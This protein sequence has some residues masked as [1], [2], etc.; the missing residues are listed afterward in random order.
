MLLARDGFSV[1][2]HGREQK[3]LE[4][5]KASILS[6]FPSSILETFCYDLSLMSNTKEFADDV[7]SK[8]TELSIL[9]NNAGVFQQSQII[10]SEELESTFAINVI[11]V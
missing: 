6:K 9:V 2:L 10:T 8:H 1:L 11:H 5:T 3:R 4:E 7:L